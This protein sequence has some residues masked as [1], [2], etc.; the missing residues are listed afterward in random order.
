MPTPAT[1][2]HPPLPLPPLPPYSLPPRRF[3]FR[4]L[5][6]QAARAPLGGAREVALACLMAA[7]LAGSAA[8]A[9]TL[10]PAARA[11]RLSAARHW[12]AALALP[13]PVRAAVA[14]FTDAAAADDPR[15]LAEPLAA[16]LGAARR[17]LDRAGAAELEQLVAALRDAGPANGPAG[18]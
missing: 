10:A 9:S 1:D 12:F 2:P 13:A 11:E 17:H 3:P 8:A 7:R 6:A 16:L 15:R 14:R 4:A 18:R 5:T